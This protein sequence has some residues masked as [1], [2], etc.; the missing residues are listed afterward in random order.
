M[1]L[2]RVR[3]EAI[4]L[5]TSCSNF[6]K[7]LLQFSESVAQKLYQ[8]PKSC[9]KVVPKNLGFPDT[10]ARQWSLNSF[11]L[12]HA[13]TF[14]SSDPRTFLFFSAALVCT[15]L[16]QDTGFFWSTWCSSSIRHFE[17]LSIS[18]DHFRL[19]PQADHQGNSVFWLQKVCYAKS[20]LKATDALN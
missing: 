9:S 15:F 7:K 8:N 1:R 20:C 17:L 4:G 19:L 18:A 3:L 12:S 6:L 16:F 14:G 10:V 5:S 2:W 13:D 11:T